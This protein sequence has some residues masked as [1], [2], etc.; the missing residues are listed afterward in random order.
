MTDA[1]APATGY[2]PRMGSTTEHTLNLGDRPLPYT[3]IADWQPL[4][5][6][7]KPVAEMFAVAYLANTTNTAQ[8]PITFVFNGGPG[9]A[10]AYL[11]MG[12][13]GPQRIVFGPNGTLPKPPV[14]LAENLESWLPFTDLVFIDPIGTGFSRSIPQEHDSP[15]A[16]N[17]KPSA[18]DPK[19]P[20]QETEFWEVER[21]L[22]ALGEF[23]QRFLSKHNR[24][25]SPVFIAGESYGGFR[26]ARLSRKLQQDFGIGLNGAILISPALEFGYLY[27][28]DYNLSAW[29]TL[30]P[31]LAAAAAHH[32]RVQWAGAPGDLAAHLAA[33]ETFTRRTL[34]PFL[35]IGDAASPEE[36]Q[37]VYGQLAG[38]IGLPASLI[39]RNGGRIALDVF[40]R[41][42]LRDRQRILGIYDASLTAIDPFPHR[43]TY[44]GTD[45]T[46]DGIDRLFNSAINNHLRATLGVATDLTYHLLN[47]ETFKAWKFDPKGELK[48][49]FIG[50]VDDLRVGMTL[51]PYLKVYITHGFYD[52]VTPYFASN[53]LVDLMRLDPEIRPNLTLKHYHGGHMFYAWETSRTQWVQDIDGFYHGAIAT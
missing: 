47:F 28:T 26:V 5:E 4:Y 49:G 23:M 21:D 1:S 42:L 33:A 24:W 9:A 32:D 40:A 3:A 25:L 12:A 15:A 37:T 43:V 52:L 39:E 6:R 20:P 53:H 51:N 10:S 14:Q 44:E 38:F 50:A 18:P 13:L 8:R 30:V 17:D 16:N 34:I 7:D 19:K 11:H 29:V 27:P 48:Q 31:S 36:R 45:P 35:A 46:L 22:K 41:E 2:T